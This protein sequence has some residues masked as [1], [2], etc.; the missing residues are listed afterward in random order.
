MLN[1][2]IGQNNI[3]NLIDFQYY[4]ILSANYLENSNYAIN[5]IF[6]ALVI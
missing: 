2:K 3:K 1:I 6:L 5:Y 4:K